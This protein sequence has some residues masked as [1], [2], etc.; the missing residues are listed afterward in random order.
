MVKGPT[1][2]LQDRINTAR[3]GQDPNSIKLRGDLPGKAPTWQQQ[4]AGE[5]AADARK[6]PAP[7]GNPGMTPGHVAQ[8]PGPGTGARNTGQQTPAGP[9]PPANWQQLAAE[10]MTPQEIMSG[11]G[12]GG[13]GSHPFQG[14]AGPTPAPGGA[15]QTTVSTQGG[16]D[17]AANAGGGAGPNQSN[18]L[19]RQVPP[20]IGA[21]GGGMPTQ[22]PTSPPPPGMGGGPST[23]GSLSGGFGGAGGGVTNG[24]PGY[25]PGG[26]PVG[27]GGSGTIG[28][29]NN[30]G[31]QQ[32][33]GA[34]GGQNLGMPSIGGSGMTLPGGG[35]GMPPMQGLQPPGGGG[36]NWGGWNSWG[37]NPAGGLSGGMQNLLRSTMG[38][39]VANPGQAPRPPMQTTGFHP[40]MGGGQL[41]R[42]GGGGMGG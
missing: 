35:S 23:G 30:V 11:M 13:A 12:Q 32:P 9:K 36:A 19:V 34:G 15:G 22:Y 16:S 21:S 10:G 14:D 6:P 40:A 39:G 42:P 3:G 2:Q 29:P 18:P 37:Q 28:G 27:G 17:A 24:P 38:S 8:P 4:R 41:L 26:T 7:V 1:R 33:I 20:G 5:R 25:N 31:M